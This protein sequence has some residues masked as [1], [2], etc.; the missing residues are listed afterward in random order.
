MEGTPGLKSTSVAS[1]RKQEAIDIEKPLESSLPK[2][3]IFWKQIVF[4]SSY[5]VG[6]K[7]Y[8]DYSALV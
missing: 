4:H 8:D 2:K 3:E 6:V 1:L 5:D 7:D